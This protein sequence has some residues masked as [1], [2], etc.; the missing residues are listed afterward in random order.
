MNEDHTNR[1]SRYTSEEIQAEMCETVEH[2][3]RMITQPDNRVDV[4]DEGEPVTIEYR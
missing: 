4:I 1:Q 3:T 2:I